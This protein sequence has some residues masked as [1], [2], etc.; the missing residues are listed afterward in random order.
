MIVYPECRF[1]CLA[2]RSAIQDRVLEGFLHD[3]VGVQ[4]EHVV[5][6]TDPEVNHVPV[7]LGPG[8]E[9]SHWTLLRTGKRKEKSLENTS[10]T[11]S[12]ISST[13]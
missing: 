7:G 9:Q 4:Q 3:P 12:E 6:W 8:T 5:C 10:K 2:R 13:P 1:A 11:P